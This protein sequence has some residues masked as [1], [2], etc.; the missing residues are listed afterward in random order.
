MLSK[1]LQ[2][3]PS[4]LISSY[5]EKDPVTYIFLSNLCCIYDRRRIVQISLN[6]FSGSVRE[7]LEGS[8]FIPLQCAFLM[9]L[10]D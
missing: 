2:V 3:K 4:K 6:L 9:G 8:R 1:L 7:A 5:L 10:H